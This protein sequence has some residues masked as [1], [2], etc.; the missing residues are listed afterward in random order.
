MPHNLETGRLWLRP[1]LPA[2]AEIAYRLFDEQPDVWK[3][4][5][6]HPRTF[7]Q[8]QHTTEKYAREN[9]PDGFGTLAMVL[10]T[11]GQLIG[12]AGL[13]RFLLPSDA[14]NVYEAGIFYKLGRD[15]WGQ[16]FAHEACEALIDFAFLEMGVNRLV[17]LTDPDNER[18]IRLL[19]RLGMQFQPA[20]RGW[21]RSLIGVLENSKLS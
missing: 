4:D 20:P 6:G 7:E 3:F 15:Y 2:D 14:G 18:S 17:G 5:P 13:E 12:Y 9:E 11:G 8:R 16:G 21:S 1:F 19:T 10:K